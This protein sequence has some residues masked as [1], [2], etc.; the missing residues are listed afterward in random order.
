MMWI[1]KPHK[2]LIQKSLYTL[3]KLM[4]DDENS[5]IQSSISFVKDKLRRAA[6]LKPRKILAEKK[7]KP[8][9]VP[10]H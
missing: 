8:R 2:W 3:D 6:N 5:S 4:M 1:T 10:S 9:L 7:E